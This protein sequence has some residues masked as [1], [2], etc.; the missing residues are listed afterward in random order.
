MPQNW[1]VATTTLKK[2]QSDKATVTVGY[3]QPP[4]TSAADTL[5]RTHIQSQQQSAKVK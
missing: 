2:N 3:S 5:S 4:Q 1:S